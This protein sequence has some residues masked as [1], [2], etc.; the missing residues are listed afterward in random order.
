MIRNTR[1]GVQDAQRRRVYRQ[2]ETHKKRLLMAGVSK[3]E[4]LRL[5]RCCR[6]SL[7]REESCLDCPKRRLKTGPYQ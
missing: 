3:E 7:C 6:A 1:R 5:L 2:I 4:I